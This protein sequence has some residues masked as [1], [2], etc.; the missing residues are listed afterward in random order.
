MISGHQTKKKKKKRERERETERE[1]ES[2][3]EKE[4]RIMR[5]KMIQNFETKWSYR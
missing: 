5:A 1:M 4:F 2:L 3:P